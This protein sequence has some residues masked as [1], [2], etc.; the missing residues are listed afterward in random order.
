MRSR[1]LSRNEQP[2]SLT[3]PAVVPE[4]T[5]PSTLPAEIA[6]YDDA[7]AML[8]A[9]RADEAHNALQ[10]HRTTWPDSVLRPEVDVSDLEALLRAGRDQEARALATVLVDDVRVRARREEIQRLLNGKAGP[11]GDSVGGGL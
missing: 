2:P 11:A 8:A 4:P 9:G 3:A 6:A 1:R 5:T 10:L 7:V